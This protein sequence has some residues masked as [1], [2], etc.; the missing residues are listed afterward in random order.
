M[1]Q[2]RWILLCVTVPGL[3][4]AAS[5]AEAQTLGFTVGFS[6][7]SSQATTI[8]SEVNVTSNRGFYVDGEN[9]QPMA[10]NSVLNQQTQFSIRDPD[11][12]FS[13][14]QQDLTGRDIRTVETQSNT[15]SQGG[16]TSLSVFTS[17]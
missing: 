16:S 14:I 11:Q 4:L 3:L 10:G 2:S 7:Q 8:S 9:V 13:L 6:T 12:A 17:F 5:Q 1:K 15:L